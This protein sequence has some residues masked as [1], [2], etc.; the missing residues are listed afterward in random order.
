[1]WKTCGEAM[2]N[3]QIIHGES[4]L[5]GDGCYSNSVTERYYQGC[6]NPV[7]DSGKLSSPNFRAI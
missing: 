4:S 5:L 2:D 6:Q 3:D 7:A 1:M